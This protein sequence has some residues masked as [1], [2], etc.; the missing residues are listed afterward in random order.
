MIKTLQKGIVILM[1]L[2]ICVQGYGV[3]SFDQIVPPASLTYGL[4]LNAEQN[5]DS[6]PNPSDESD[7]IPL[8]FSF[9]DEET[10]EDCEDVD[11]LKVNNSLFNGLISALTLL[12]PNSY[13]FHIHYPIA[14][15]T[16]PTPPPDTDIHV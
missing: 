7:T 12:K 6:L 1:G 8:P 11:D 4:A 16:I 9:P 5:P 15:S 3:Y 10:K 13:P 2:L 14:V